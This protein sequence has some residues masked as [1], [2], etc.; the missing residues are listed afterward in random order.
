MNSTVVLF[1]LGEGGGGLW[2]NKWKILQK[3]SDKILLFFRFLGN[4]NI[5]FICSKYFQ[6]LLFSHEF[7]Y[8]WYSIY[9][10]QI[11]ELKTY[12]KTLNVK[13]NN[14]NIYVIVQ[15]TLEDWETETEIWETKFIYMEGDSKKQISKFQ[16]RMYILPLNTLIVDNYLIIGTYSDLFQKKKAIAHKLPCPKRYIYTAIDL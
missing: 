10:N 12:K 1:L 11:K 14:S 7:L 3:N 8:I 16:F 15:C 5:C 13:Q 4:E 6:I 9:S 2:V